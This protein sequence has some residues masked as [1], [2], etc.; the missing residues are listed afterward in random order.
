MT[1]EEQKQVYIRKHIF[2]EIHKK[3]KYFLKYPKVYI[4][5]NIDTR[6]IRVSFDILGTYINVVYIHNN[7]FLK[8][9]DDFYN[10]VDDL[11][12]VCENIYKY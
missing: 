7:H 6:C 1:K 5:I 3:T 11:K 10:A 9:L 12:I 8:D 4:D 2:T